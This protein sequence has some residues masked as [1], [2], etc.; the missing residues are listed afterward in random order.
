MT[1]S[2][3]QFEV[4][5]NTLTNVT[6]I[7][8]IAFDVRDMASNLKLGTLEGLLNAQRIYDQGS[9]SP[10]YDIF[11]KE[12]ENKLTLKTMGQTG[13]GGDW[14]D[15]PS[16]TFQMLGFLSAQETPDEAVSKHALY[17][18]YYISQLLSD[19][20][21]A[22]N[23]AAAQ[24]AT[25]LTVHMNAMHKLWDG[26]L[27]CT[28]VQNGYNPDEDQTGKVN[29][30]RKYDEFI[31]LYVGAGQSLGPSWEGYLLYA[32]AQA[33]S[34]KFQTIDE[35]GEALVN[36]DI[37]GL[38]EWI[39]R[40]M[41]EEDYCKRDESISE[42]WT[43]NNRIIAKMNTSMMQM[44]IHSMYDENQ[45][46][47]VPVYARTIVPQLSQC[48]TSI[49]RK[50]K[51]YLLDKTYDR[52]DFSRILPLLQQ[53]YDCLGFS[54]ENVG[55]YY[56]KVAECG[57]LTENHPMAGFVPKDDV[58][59]LSKVDL[60]ILAI[61]QLLSLP[62]GAYNIIPQMYYK[63][64][65][66]AV[67]NEDKYGY[68]V[69]SLQDMA[70]SSNILEWSPYY[71]DYLSYH[72]KEYYADSIILDEFKKNAGA[73]T[74]QDT[75]LLSWMQFGV[76]CEYMMGLLGTADQTC[77]DGNDDNPTKYWD[78]FAA[79]YIGS[80]E[81]VDEGGSDQT[82]DGFMLWNVANKRAAS[83]N[84][85][86][87]DYFAKINE[88]MLELLF[89][90]Q[91]QLLRRDCTNFGKTV[92]RTLHLMIIPLIQN[93]IWYAIQNK[94]LSASS[95]D[96]DLIMG[97]VTAKSVIPIVEK[98]DP[99]A[100]KI[101]ER[102]MVRSEENFVPV[103]DGPQAVANAFYS[104]LDEIGWGCDYIGRAEGIDA[105][106]GRTQNGFSKQ[107]SSDRVISIL[108][109]IIVAWGIS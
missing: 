61:S 3:T 17:A 109:P 7:S 4:G 34:K 56:D 102:N 21:T 39:Q 78:A 31:A 75:T 22:E 106:L 54:C 83:F 47:L 80:L 24:A 94:G 76:V 49:H 51:S 91:S 45:Y 41:S 52:E 69:L 53:S 44:L 99:N 23:A 70:R 63:F 43:I 15:D 107:G 86:N 6:S 30:K 9:N 8:R 84:T 73:D 72:G 58:Q 89:S 74:Q 37:R 59:T 18:D 95:K 65:R 66:A 36:K 1:L 71:S 13:A 90:G 62:T 35:N 40:I 104:V 100:A 27:D 67:I 46:Y 55:A 60:D 29:P 48:R 42:L 101:I 92:S 10:I 14:M 32:V 2:T 79:Y 26:F 64:G 87:S 98:Y 68:D 12:T 82:I 57:D 81:G 11:G 38:Y 96:D 33:A 28:K 50:L 77:E 19:Q 108:L 5:I 103:V 97:E 93:T 16:F 88:E 25:I 20:T 105:C 85:Q